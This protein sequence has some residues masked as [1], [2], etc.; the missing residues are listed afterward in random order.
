MVDK[1][2]KSPDF[3]SGGGF[4]PC[5]FKSR[6]RRQLNILLRDVACL[7]R[8]LSHLTF[9]QVIAGSNPVH[10][11]I[12]CACGGI[13]RHM[14]LKP[15]SFGVQVRLLSGAPKICPFGGIG[16]RTRLRIGREVIVA[17]EF[18]SPKGHHIMQSWWNGIH[19]A[20]RTLCRKD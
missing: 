1:L 19:V 13:G 2:V 12:V 8:G 15:P 10:A 11:S 6:P 18:E 9:N 17:W 4:P 7:T 20:L 5:G 16:R 14:G 3:Q